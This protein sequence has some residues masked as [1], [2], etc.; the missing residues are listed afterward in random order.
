MNNTDA[1]HMFMTTK[2]LDGAVMGILVPTV[3]Y[4]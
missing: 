2:Q 4:Y 1:S 3:I